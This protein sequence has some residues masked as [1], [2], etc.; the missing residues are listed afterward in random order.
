PGCSRRNETR[1]VDSTIS[2]ARLRADSSDFPADIMKPTTAPPPSISTGLFIAFGRLSIAYSA[3]T[4]A[5][6]KAGAVSRDSNRRESKRI[7]KSESGSNIDTKQQV[8]PK[9]P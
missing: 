4:T 5:S 9:I 8:A 1:S 6:D 7:V 3:V 2:C